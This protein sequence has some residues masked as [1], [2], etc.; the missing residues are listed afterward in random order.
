MREVETQRAELDAAQKSAAAEQKLLVREAQ[1]SLEARLREAKTFLDDA[2][3]SLP[4]LAK[5]HASELRGVLD[6]LEGKLVGATLDDTR[7]EF[8]GSL[9]KGDHVWVPRYRRKCPIT[10]IFKEKE[11]VRVLMGRQELEIGFEEISTFDTL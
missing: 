9:K 11:R 3:K 6:A 8:L 5:D 7:K 4:R 2:R 10:R 1:S